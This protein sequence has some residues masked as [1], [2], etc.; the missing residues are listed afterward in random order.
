MARAAHARLVG[1]DIGSSGLRAVEVHR[2]V[3]ALPEIVRAANLDLPAGVITSGTI[4][5]E[6]ALVAGLKRLWRAGRFGTRNVAIALADATLLTRQMDLPWMPADDFR[7]ALRY[8]VQDALPVDTATV[9]LDAHTLGESHSIDRSGHAVETKRV[10]V[11]AADRSTTV[12]MAEAVRKAHLAPM[13][14]DSSA[15][16]LIRA[17]C[18][19]R[20]PDDDVPRVIVD[21]GAEATTVVVHAAGQPRFIRTITNTGGD[22]ATIAIAEALDLDV[23]AAE[24][25]KM[26]V[27]LNGPV[28]IVAAVS[29]SSVF[30]SL[31]EVQSMLDVRTQ[32]A[33][34]AL[35]PWA[36]G[37]VS[38]IRNSI[39]YFMSSATPET[40]IASITLCGRA[41]LLDGLLERIATQVPYAV[42]RLDRFVGLPASQR[43]LHDPP[44]D[45]RYAVAI[46][47]AL[48]VAP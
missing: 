31:A 39:D 34:D 6:H 19:G 5:D 44:P 48:S 23:P 2:R 22:H 36:T 32:S 26:Q 27:G 18:H 45:A 25:L 30:S 10:L 20:L 35:N 33:V 14:I 21:I 29:E 13:I 1:L 7:S 37:I 17:V 11:V 4:G 47:L 28:P 43:V 15:F 42:H 40:S 8:Q 24:S 9:E 46:G 38:E 12:A 16:A 41:S 3:G